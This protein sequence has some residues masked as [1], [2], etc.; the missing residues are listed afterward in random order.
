[1]D[2]GIRTGCNFKFNEMLAKR[3][4]IGN[5]AFRKHVIMWVVEEYGVSIASACTH[6]NHSFK[7]VKRVAPELVEGL[8]RPEDKKGGR[9]PKAKVEAVTV[10]ETKP[11]TYNVYKK[12]DASLVASDL[13]FE[14]ATALVNK[15]AAQKKAKLYFW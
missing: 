4:E 13:S 12:A 6:Y 15:A 5:K 2:K 10:I 9:K 11:V 1:M 14:D 8:G 3:A 7:E